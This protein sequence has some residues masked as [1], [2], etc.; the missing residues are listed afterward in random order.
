MK[1]PVVKRVV[2]EIPVV[3]NYGYGHSYHVVP[4]QGSSRVSYINHV[5][6]IL[7][8]IVWCMYEKIR[9]SIY[10]LSN[11]HYSSINLFLPNSLC[12]IVPLQL[13]R[14]LTLIHIYVFF[15][16]ILNSRCV[17]KIF[18]FS[19]IYLI[20]NLISQPLLIKL[21]YTFRLL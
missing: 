4:S 11:Y 6:I 13:K 20:F 3:L 7:F 19:F 10:L 18:F 1:F 9:I 16:C 21:F 2:K 17:L 14:Y 5:F 15:Y 12:C 8:I